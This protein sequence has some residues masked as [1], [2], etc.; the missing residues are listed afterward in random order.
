MPSTT[1]DGLLQTAHHGTLFLDEISELPWKPGQAA[2]RFGVPQHSSVGSTD[3]L[4]VDTRILAA[5]N[6]PL[7]QRVRDGRFRADLFYRLNV[8]R[9]EIPPLRQQRRHP[10]LVDRFLAETC[11]RA[12]RDLIGYHRRC[13]A[14][15]AS[16]CLPRQR[17][18]SFSTSSSARS[19]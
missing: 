3:S 18:V 5:S 12:G 15:A 9:L 8:I 16:A 10:A 13:A 1:R 17:C 14:Q 7:E 19:S 4:P 11:L 2:A 6:Q